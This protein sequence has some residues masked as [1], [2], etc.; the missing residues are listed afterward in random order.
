MELIPNSKDFWRLW[1]VRV[2]A[3]GATA[4][5]YWTAIPA[6]DQQKLLEALPVSPSTLVLLTFVANIAA[7]VVRQPDIAPLKAGGPGEE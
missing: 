2:S 6:A 5:A 4:A 7:R 3:I 1:S